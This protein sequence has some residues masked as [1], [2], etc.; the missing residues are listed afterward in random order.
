MTAEGGWQELARFSPDGSRISFDEVRGGR[1]V[2]RGQPGKVVSEQAAVFTVRSDGSDL[3]QVTPWGIHGADADWSPD[4]TKLVFAGQPTHVGAN[5][6][7][8]TAAVLDRAEPLHA[9]GYPELIAALRPRQET[10][11]GGAGALRTDPMDVPRAIAAP[12]ARS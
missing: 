10:G 11:Q 7:R 9:S 12:R 4:G 5:Q 2:Q 8:Y 6:Q 3:R 1:E